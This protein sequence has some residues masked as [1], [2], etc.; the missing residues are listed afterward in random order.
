[1]VF[2]VLNVIKTIVDIVSGAINIV[3]SIKS[4]FTAS[5]KN[6]KK[7]HRSSGKNQRWKYK[8]EF[9]KIFFSRFVA[10][11]KRSALERVNTLSYFCLYWGFSSRYDQSYCDRTHSVEMDFKPFFIIPIILFLSM[12]LL[13][14]FF[15]T[16]FLIYLFTS[17][18]LCY[19]INSSCVK[20][21]GDL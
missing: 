1:M 9:I 2:L 15:K 17:N 13:T 18:S 10:L 21:G 14:L 12:C 16:I 3:K 20:I 4:D 8:Q 19:H 11:F 7:N 5:D 6:N